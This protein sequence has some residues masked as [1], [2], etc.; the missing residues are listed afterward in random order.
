MPYQ[1]QICGDAAT[2]HAGWRYNW[3][4]VDSCSQ[5]SVPYVPMVWRHTHIHSVNVSANGWLMGP[6]EPNYRGQAVA[7]PQEVADVW[8]LF[9][10]TGRRLVSPAVSACEDPNDSNC[11]NPNWLEQWVAACEGC[12]YEAVALHWYGCNVSQFTSYLDRRH[13]Q[14]PGKQIWVTEF[15]CQRWGN[16]EWFMRQAIDAIERRPWITRYAWFATRTND[17]P[18]MLPLVD[19]GGL[20]SLGEVYVE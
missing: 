11:L 9:E 5:S 10:A 18:W 1:Y 7:S 14:F 8:H 2:L 17:W 12:R 4:Y 16:P 3:S 15:G 13:A 6:N 20:T 19:G